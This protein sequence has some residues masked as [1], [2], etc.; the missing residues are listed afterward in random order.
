MPAELVQG[1]VPIGGVPP[2]LVQRVQ[3]HLVATGAVATDGANLRMVVAEVLGE[4]GVHLGPPRLAA[5]VRSIGDELTGL[6]P[7]APLLADPTV[8]DVM[9]NGPADVWVERGGAI[10]RA[11]VRFA[12]AAAVAALVQRVVA[13]LGLRV[14]ESRPWVDARLPG[15]ERFHAVLPPLAPDGPVV[16][17]RTFARRR[18]QLRDLIDRNALDAATARL[19]EAMVAA[20]IAI[21]V[22]GATGTGKT[23]LLNVRERQ[24][25]A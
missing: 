17:I 12:S 15:G 4:D 2:G 22:S 19:L 13:P 5:L 7:L 23:T 11:A 21:A 16:T 20:G 14:D 18:L 24:P 9:V 25:T 3:R 10:E 6:G 1:T 8:T